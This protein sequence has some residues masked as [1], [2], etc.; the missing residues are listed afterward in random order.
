MIMKK[1]ILFF[2]ISF[3]VF[4]LNAQVGMGADLFPMNKA[5]L[6]TKTASSFGFS[7]KIPAAYSLKSYTPYAKS[8][9]N[10]G[11]CTSWAV[12]YSAM[13]TQY[14]F[15][16]NITNRNIITSLAFCPLYLHNNVRS[17]KDTCA[18]GNHVIN[19][20][21]YAV[22]YGNKRYY[23]PMIGC[24][25]ATDNM[26]TEAAS[27]SRAT[28]AYSL[29]N[30]QG[31]WPDDSANAV[32]FFEREKFDLETIKKCLLD[33]K[34]PIF[35]MFVPA[36]FGSVNDANWN[37][38]E[39]EKN[40]PVSAVL[41]QK[42]IM[43][44]RHAMTIVSYD[45]NRNG[46]SFEIMNSWGTDFGDKGFVWVKYDDLQKYTYTVDYLDMPAP[47]STLSEGC[48][49]DCYSGY[50]LQKFNNGDFYE[51]FFKNG[52]FDGYGVYCH[53][54]GATYAGEFKDGMRNGDAY[55]YFADGTFGSAIYSND[56][57]VSGY[58]IVSYADG[59]QYTGNLKNGLFDG[60]GKL[61]FA[62]GDIYQGTFVNGNYEGLG[63]FIYA[64]GKVH[65]GYY[66]ANQ[67]H[68]KGLEY[69][70]DGK[71]WAGEWT[72]DKFTT[73]SK[74]GFAGKNTANQNI[75]APTANVDYLKAECVSGDCTSGFGK[76]VYT[77]QG[78]YEGGFRDGQEYGIGK[79]NQTDGSIIEG[80]FDGGFNSWPGLIVARF[81]N[82]GMMIGRFEGSGW[83]G[84]VA[85]F[86]ASGDIGIQKYNQGTFIDY[87]GT[88]N[89]YTYTS[90]SLPKHNSTRIDPQPLMT[91]GK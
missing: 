44:E 58:D 38:N 53:A 54:N 27:F 77:N 79:I 22:N 91:T 63:K 57:I 90:S 25:V 88:A 24:A 75:L 45:D 15:L 29:Y 50:G 8:Q 76:R 85:C 2:S 21:K 46:G 78:S 80:F 12:G 72:Y 68:G 84:Y 30:H 37:L 40:D 6:K 64:D 71:V 51:G 19:V 5:E 7:S 48:T 33:N 89:N 73:G 4:Q 3:G 43:H 39:D 23:S 17:V 49:G 81:T 18:R 20:A 59:S 82:G 86:Y 60:Y 41:A 35:A 42:G 9:G 36:S 16:N 32:L 26:M 87:M 11:T 70:T 65:F 14:A 83:D 66:S 55:T 31:P 56:K 10:Y 47:T 52:K 13:T 1:V 67:K 62:T 61:K 28:D 34:L 69:T 74:Y